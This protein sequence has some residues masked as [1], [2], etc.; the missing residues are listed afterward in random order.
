MSFLPS[1]NKAG[2]LAGMYLIN[3]IPGPLTIFWNWAPANVAGATKRAFVTA[4]I[5]ALSAA[6]AATGPQT[7]QAKDAPG[8][9]PAKITALATQAAA[10]VLI[11]G[12]YAWYRL[13][14]RKRGREL[15]GEK[16][17]EGRFMEREVWERSTDREN[18]GFRYVY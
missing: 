8:Y 15:V 14:N 17:V 5:G 7:F 13:Q 3:F 18:R 9:R 11:L 6:G 1:S 16:E 10:A 12:L 2:L 4:M